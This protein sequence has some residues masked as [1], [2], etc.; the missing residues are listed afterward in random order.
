[1]KTLTEMKKVH[2]I[3]RFSLFIIAL[4]LTIGFSSCGSDDAD[5]PKFS[6]N[7]VNGHYAG[8][9]QTIAVEPQN[10]STAT[11]E[12]GVNVTAEVKDN[13]II[14][15]KFPIADLI[16]SILGDNEASAGIIEAIGDVNYQVAYQGSFNDKQDVINMKL[17]PKPLEISFK[18]P[19]TKVEGEDEANDFKVKVTITTDEQGT[20]AYANHKLNFTLHATEVFLNESETPFDGFHA[21][22]FKFDLNKK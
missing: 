8:K 22:S 3:R 4:G 17:D 11:P 1:M 15:N 9:M 12:T 19:I 7:D 2:C 16:K 6:L 21:S 14:L 13:N 20:F 10:R 18:M 5:I